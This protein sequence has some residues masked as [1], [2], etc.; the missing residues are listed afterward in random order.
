MLALIYLM[1]N[2]CCYIVQ[3]LNFERF[4]YESRELHW[5]RAGPARGICAW[6]L[7]IGKIRR[8]LCREC[9]HFCCAFTPHTHLIDFLGWQEEHGVPE[10]E[11]DGHFLCTS[12]LIPKFK[13]SYNIP[14]RRSFL[15]VLQICVSFKHWEGGWDHPSREELCPNNIELRKSTLI[16]IC[17]SQMK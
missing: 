14:F 17:L 12:K 13:K 3:R 8:L 11:R 1:Y 15:F 7:W 16:S 5:P 6:K 4:G 9:E 10:R 2:G